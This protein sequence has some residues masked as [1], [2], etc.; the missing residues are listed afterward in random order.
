MFKTHGQSQGSHELFSARATQHHISL[1][2]GR[3]GAPFQ[4]ASIYLLMKSKPLS[5]RNDEI[6]EM[7]RDND[8]G[9]VL[10]NEADAMR[11]HYF[12]GGRRKQRQEQETKRNVL[13][14][15]LKKTDEQEKSEGIR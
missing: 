9:F 15:P 10:E 5:L 11:S 8:R 2:A 13:G 12:S 4:P 14:P 3:S 7:Q 1:T 6:S